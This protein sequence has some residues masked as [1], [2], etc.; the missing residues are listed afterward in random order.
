MPE[1]TTTDARCFMIHPDGQVWEIDADG[2][3]ADDWRVDGLYA[4]LV[5]AGYPLPSDPGYPYDGVID[6]AVYPG[7]RGA[8]VAHT[9]RPAGEYVMTDDVFRAWYVA[10]VRGALS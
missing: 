7:A 3:I 2:E 5:L 9:A 4:E 8:V 6:L 10:N 1:T